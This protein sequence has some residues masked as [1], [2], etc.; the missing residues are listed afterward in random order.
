MYNKMK[1]SLIIK[2]E[3]HSQ[4]KQYCDE[5]GIKINKLIENLII[6]YLKNGQRESKNE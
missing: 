4:L 6:Q 5:Q 2:E 3:I 1:K